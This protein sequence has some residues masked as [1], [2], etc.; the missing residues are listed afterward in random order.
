MGSQVCPEGGLVEFRGV[1]RDLSKNVCQALESLALV[2]RDGST[3]EFEVD[4]EGV[5]EMLLWEL[6]DS[7]DET[8]EST[9]EESVSI[10]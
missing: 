6:L 5:E 10:V 4:A 2:G 7:S 1:E 9:S 8:D 3:L